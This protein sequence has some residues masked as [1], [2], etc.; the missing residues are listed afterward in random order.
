M[1]TI[2]KADGTKVELGDKPAF[3]KI[4]EAVGGYVELV[5]S[6][7]LQ[8]EGL[9]LAVNEDGRLLKLEENPHASALAGQLI[10]GDVVVVE[11]GEI[12]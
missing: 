7:A 2:L 6:P 12:E 3:A 5:G 9:A 11:D 10:V 4:Q 8:R 1:A